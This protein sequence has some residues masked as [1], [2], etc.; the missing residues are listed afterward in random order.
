MRGIG[1]RQSRMLADD[2]EEVECNLK[3]WL[4]G[5]QRLVDGQQQVA[6]TADQLAQTSAVLS[7]LL[8]YMVEHLARV[9][10]VEPEAP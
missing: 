5:G 9:G 8:P 4:L 6:V 2:L 1:Q 7:D 3:G 10:W